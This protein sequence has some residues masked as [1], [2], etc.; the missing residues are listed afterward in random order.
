MLALL[1][2]LQALKDYYLGHSDGFEVVFSTSLSEDS[3]VL[4][5]AVETG[6]FAANRESVRH[7]S[8]P[9]LMIYVVPRLRSIAAVNRN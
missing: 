2:L 4:T 1:A 8:C 5:L 9:D 7:K 6:V 3:V